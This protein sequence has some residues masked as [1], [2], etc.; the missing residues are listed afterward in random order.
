MLIDYI[1]TSTN[2]DLQEHLRAANE[3][4]AARLYGAWKAAGNSLA[5][6]F[7]GFAEAI[8][9][10]RR[11]RRTNRELSALSDRQL[12]D[13]GLHRAQ[14]ADVAEAVAAQA[15]A[16]GLSIADLRQGGIVAEPDLRGRVEPPPRDGRRQPRPAPW[17]AR[18][19][20]RATARPARQAA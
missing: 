4:R 3:A 9:R 11:A 2:P 12:R 20:A 5:A 14:I 1:Q 10:T 18:R 19:P 8:R 16:T 6:P 7:R 17:A 13:I 15:P